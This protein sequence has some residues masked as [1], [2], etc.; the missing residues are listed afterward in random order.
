MPMDIPGKFPDETAFVAGSNPPLA[1]VTFDE[2]QPNADRHPLLI[3]AAGRVVVRFESVQRA[4]VGSAGAWYIDGDNVWSRLPAPSRRLTLPRSTSDAQFVADGSVLVVTD[5][6]N[7][8]AFLVDLPWLQATTDT[9]PTLDDDKQALVD[10]VCRG[11]A[12]TMVDDAGLRAAMQD[13]EP[14]AC[15]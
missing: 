4:V 5:A 7:G 10:F 6:A 11:P 14:S 9:I 3:D 13:R 8:T 15:R 2:T 12:G 1:L